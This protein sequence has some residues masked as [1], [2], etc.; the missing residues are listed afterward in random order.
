VTEIQVL[1]PPLPTGQTLELMVGGKLIGQ[2]K[3]NDL[4]AVQDA[5][6]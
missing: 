1:D 4:I 2:Y 3:R 6:V 5:D